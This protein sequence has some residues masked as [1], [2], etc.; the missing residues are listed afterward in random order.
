[1]KYFRELLAKIKK[2]DETFNLINNGDKVVVGISGGKDSI[3]LFEALMTYAKYSKKDFTLIPVILDLGFPKFSAATYIKHF[4]DRGY[5]LYI[6]DAQNVAQIL[7]IQKERQKLSKLPCSICSKMKKA[8][9]NSVANS[10]GA[11]KV[12]FAHH[13]DDA[14]ETLV[15]NMI[16]GGRLATFQPKMLLERAKITFIRPLI[17]TSE[18][19]VTNVLKELNLPLLDYAC[20]NNKKTRREDIKNLLLS[21]Y[22][23]YESAQKNFE[24]MLVNT[25]AFA[26]WY[27]AFETSV[28]KDL[29]LVKV[30]TPAQFNDA[31]YI[32]YKVFI[33]E[34][35]IRIEDEYDKNEKDY[36]TYVL[37]RKDKPIATIRYKID[38]KERIASIG[39][40]AVIKDERNQGLATLM[41]NYLENLLTVKYR[42]LTITIGGQKHLRPFYEKRGYVVKGEPYL[43]AFIEHYRLEKEI[44]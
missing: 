9:I 28:G 18:S 22:K 12:A 13:I 43:D 44:K 23:T 41:L 40:I 21:I 39:R 35:K 25:E 16:S 19:L 4:K 14:L 36:T 24:L 33:E 34:Q 1:M 11:N 26:M 3:V 10:L 7:E 42:P 15:M 37:Y 8:A 30:F 5:T 31:M 38:K 20:P 6:S 29:T 2:A 17:L 32:R 27:N